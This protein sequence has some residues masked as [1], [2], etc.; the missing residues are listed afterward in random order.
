MTKRALFLLP[1]LPVFL[2]FGKSPDAQRGPSS[3]LRQDVEKLSALLH[4]DSFREA[5]RLA[6][7]LMADHAVDA[8]TL[9]LCGLAVLKAGRVR[10]AEVLFNKVI[11]RSPDNPEAHLGLGRIGRIRNDLDAALTHLRRAVASAGFY[12]EALRQLWRTARAAIDLVMDPYGIPEVFE[13]PHSKGMIRA[14]A[15]MRGVIVT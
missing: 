15:S 6:A 11:S 1:F 8:L 7:A 3:P 14:S 10:E 2:I 4:G 5:E 12:E 9:A 13:V